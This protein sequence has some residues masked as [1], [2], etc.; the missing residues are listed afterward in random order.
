MYERRKFLKDYQEKKLS[1]SL[2]ENILNSASTK[3]KLEDYLDSLFSELS[4]SIHFSVASYAIFNKKS[5]YFRAFV[6]DFVNNS[7][8]KESERYCIESA[9]NYFKDFDCIK[10]YSIEE[11]VFG[12]HLLNTN[13]MKVEGNFFIPLVYAE[14]FIGIVAFT[15]KHKNIYTNDLVDSNKKI[16]VPF[17]NYSLILQEMGM[18]AKLR[19]DYIN[20]IVHDLRTP[21]TIIMG[22]ADIVTKRI[23]ALDKKAIIALSTDIKLASKR[24]LNLIDNLLDVSRLSMKRLKLNLI[25]GDILNFFREASTQY[26]NFV[27]DSNLNYEF[28]CPKSSILYKYDQNILLRIL[29]NLI[30]NAVKYTEKGTVKLKIELIETNKIKVSV[31]DTGA[32]ITDENLKKLFEPYESVGVPYNLSFKTVG[33]GLNITKQL[34]EFIGSNLKVESKVGKGSKFYFVLNL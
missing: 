9:K 13:N 25:Q 23:K 4:S 19:E 20:T 29:D 3:T 1:S 18:Y 15:T 24:L 26:K 31:T 28:S 17:I 30:S 14:K 34:V 21:L 7:F 11:S 5:I 33:L 8:I 22:S 27:E 16:I 10:D 6:N 32:G 12:K 2:L